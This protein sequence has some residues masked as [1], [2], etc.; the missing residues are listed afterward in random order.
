MKILIVGAGGYGQGYVD[1]MLNETNP[2][3]KLE[4]IVE[5]FLDRAPHKDA[6]LAANI[7]VYNTME[8]FYAKHEADLALIATPTFLHCE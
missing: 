8:A 7:P 6:I 2:E 1:A 4:G 3:L 5:P